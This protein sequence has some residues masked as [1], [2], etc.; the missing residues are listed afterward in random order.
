M[1]DKVIPVKGTHNIEKYMN[2]SPNQVTYYENCR[3]ILYIDTCKNK[4]IKRILQFINS[5]NSQQN[6]KNNIVKS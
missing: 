6:S 1:D 3:H 2:L 4:L 5:E